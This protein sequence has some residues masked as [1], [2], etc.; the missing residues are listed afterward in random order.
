MNLILNAHR[1]LR[2]PRHGA[3]SPRRRRPMAAPGAVIEVARHGR[4]HRPRTWRRTSSTRS[5]PPRTPAAASGCYIAHRIVT[6]H[7]GAHPTAAARRR[8]NGVRDHAP[9][10]RRRHVR[11]RHRLSG[12]GAASCPRCPPRRRARR[13][14]RLAR[15]P[16]ADAGRRRAR[17]RRRRAGR[18]RSGSRCRPAAAARCSRARCTPRR[19]ARARSSPPTG[20]GRALRDLPP[21][22]SVLIDAESPH[23]ARRARRSRRCSTTDRVGAARLGA[24]R[25]LPLPPVLAPRLDAVTLRVPPLASARRRAAGARAPHLL[26]VAERAARR[27]PPPASRAAALAWLAAQPW[28]GDVAELEAVAGAGA[29]RARSAADRSTRSPRLDVERPR[30]SRRRRRRITR[31]QLEYPRRAAGARAAQPARHRQDVRRS[32]P[33]SPTIAELRA[34]FAAAHRRCH[35]PHGRPAGE[36][37]RVRAPRAPR[38]PP[39]SSSGPLLDGLLAEVRPGARRARRRASTTRRRTARAASP[40]ASSSPMR[41]ATCS[42]A[43]RARCRPRTRVRVDAAPP[44]RV[45]IEFD[46]R[47]GT[48]E[49]LARR[50]AATTALATT[51]RDAAAARVHAGARGA[52]AQRRRARACGASPTDGRCSRS[53]CPVP[54]RPEGG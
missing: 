13:C 15:L 51:V 20:A 42:T 28:P 10:G 31:A 24:S 29:P 18:R 47:D 9:H 19:S 5:S 8:R 25:S 45:R 34:R 12:A 21:G 48:A 6:E 22:A 40:I 27:A 1:G 4:R 39:T 36:R 30:R 38:R 7:G 50:A 3:T 14:R 26:A 37:A 16:Q 41:C 2:R 54:V 49:R 32:C 17:A 43:S 11:C 53:G 52:R 33:A 46:D 44:G 35:R 23:R